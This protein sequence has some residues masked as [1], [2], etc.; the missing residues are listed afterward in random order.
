LQND[1]NKLHIFAIL[2]LKFYMILVKTGGTFGG[3][4]PKH[5]AVRRNRETGS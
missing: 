5:V 3:A 1:K 4:I 2:T